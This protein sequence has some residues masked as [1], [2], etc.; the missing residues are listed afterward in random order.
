MDE[1]ILSVVLTVINNSKPSSLF[2]VV[3]LHPSSVDST[4]I[5]MEKQTRK[6]KRKRKL[7]WKNKHGKRKEKGN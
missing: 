6:T 3:F 5:R 1:S 4:E 2:N 7:E